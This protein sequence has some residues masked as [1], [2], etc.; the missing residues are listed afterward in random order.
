MPTAG[1]L[2]K[3]V[4]KLER[5]YGA[6]APP[7]ARDP[8][9]LVLWENV[10]YLVDDTRRAEVFEALRKTVGLNPSGILAASDDTLHAVA[11][12]G[13]MRP[14][15]RV[16][17]LRS[18]AEIVAERFDGDL[19]SLLRAPY[20]KAV[21]GL[22]KFPGIGEPGAEKILLFTETHP[23]LA[24]ESN[25]L[26]ALLRLGFGEE[27]GSYSTTYRSVQKAL[28]DEIRR[29]CGWLIKAHQLLRRH[30]QELCKRTVPLCE[31]CP[32]SE[33]CVYFNKRRTG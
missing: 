3:I 29:D 31:S 21:A 13:G 9:E 22:K 7:P 2:R 1:S 8:F 24:L 18:I 28:E 25:G 32:V 23:V 4:R 12:L 14:E 33:L 26:R 6:P 17:R 20:R 30:G 5:F 10:A 16:A 19:E 15:D 27:A 11:R